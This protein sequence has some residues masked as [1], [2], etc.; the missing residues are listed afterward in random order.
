M[1]NMTPRDIEVIHAMRRVITSFDAAM[2]RQRSPTR[3]G[4]PQGLANSPGQLYGAWTHQGPQQAG[5]QRRFGPAMPTPPFMP[6]GIT[7]GM[8]R[9][10]IKGKE[11][12]C[13]TCGSPGH[14]KRDCQFAKR[15][16]R[17]MGNPVYTAAA[18]PRGTRPFG[19]TPP[20]YRE[21][22]I[23]PIGFKVVTLPSPTR[24]LGTA[25]IPSI[26]NGAPPRDMGPYSYRALSRSDETASTNSSGR[27]CIWKH[28]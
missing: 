28:D 21:R 16:Y 24:G 15:H 27:S 18:Q 14:I 20:N 8:T 22:P 11:K 13:Y 1:E 7:Q 26:S 9:K 12:L 19:G 5:P 6:T 23:A 17:D 25:E 4:T 2:E 10:A 3:Q